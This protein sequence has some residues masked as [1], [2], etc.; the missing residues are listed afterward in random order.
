M[1]DKPNIQT[2]YQ[3][4]KRLKVQKKSFLDVV[5][6]EKNEF[7]LICTTMGT[8]VFISENKYYKLET[9]RKPAEGRNE[10]GHYLPPSSK[11]KRW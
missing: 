4:L 10:T 6:D 7:W 8:I 11:G 9:N 2:I 5:K 3:I 1:V